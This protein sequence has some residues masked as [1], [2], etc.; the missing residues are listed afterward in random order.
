MTHPIPCA[1]ENYL[2]PSPFMGEGPGMGVFYRML[3][4]VS[5]MPFS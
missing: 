1:V 2:L 5:F 3:F 4:T